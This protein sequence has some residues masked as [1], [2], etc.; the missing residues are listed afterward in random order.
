LR[1]YYLS[2]LDRKTFED[3][4]NEFWKFDTCKQKV[5]LNQI[6]H[7]PRKKTKLVSFTSTPIKDENNEIIGFKGFVK[8]LTDQ[9]T[10]KKGL[11]NFF[12]LSYDLHCIVH[13]SKRFIKVSPAWTRLLGYTEEELLSQSYLAFV[14]PDDLEKTNLSLD[15]LNEISRGATFENRYISKSG[16]VVHLSWNSY[17]DEETQLAYATARDV[18]KSKLAQ[19]EILSDLSA[20]ELLLREIHHRVK[21]NLQIISSL[22]SLQAGANGEH[23]Q[24]TELYEASQNRINAMA[25]IHEMFYQSEELDKIEFGKYLDKLVDDLVT[26]FHS[27]NKKIDINIDSDIVYVNLDTAIPLGLL[28]NELVTN[29]MKHGGDKH[30][31]VEVFIKMKSLKDDQLEITIGDNGTKG[32]ANILNQNVESLGIL[33]INS[34]VEQIDGEIKQ[35]EDCEGTVFSLKFV[36][37]MIFR[38]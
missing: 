24:L 10:G 18:T 27:E 8:D 13:S 11:D 19:D 37:K 21:N 15:E 1:E 28:I 31:N 14:H 9:L 38:L 36:N 35:L 26:S 30:E 12:N 16:K 4:P 25:A 33:L 34:L 7:T 3:L 22:L 2:C 32:L 17:H 6:I 23:I 5:V 29:S 20:K